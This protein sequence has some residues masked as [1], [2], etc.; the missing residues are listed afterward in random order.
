MIRVKPAISLYMLKQAL[1]YSSYREA[2]LE[3]RDFGIVYEVE[4]EILSLSKEDDF[5]NIVI[6]AT[7]GLKSM[8]DF[9]R[10]E[11]GTKLL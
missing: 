9:K 5:Q 7:D 10:S 8:M 6:Q 2:V 3:L 4:E 11:K 1:H